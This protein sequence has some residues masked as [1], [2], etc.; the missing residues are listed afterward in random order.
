MG[1]TTANPSKVIRCYNYRGE[2]HIAR[3]CTQLKRAKNS[4]WFN[5]KMQLAQAQE[6]GV[7]LDEE[8]VAFL[9]YKGER[10]DLG[11]TAQN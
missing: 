4:E 10:V 2:G 8:H 6:A 7:V 1:N 3:Q 5:E 9:A 11:T